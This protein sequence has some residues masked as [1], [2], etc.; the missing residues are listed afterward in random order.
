MSAL[1]LLAMGCQSGKSTRR[2]PRHHTIENSFTDSSARSEYVDRRT[3]ELVDKGVDRETASARASREWFAH[4]PVATQVPTA[5]ELKR[6]QAEADITA[7]LE[8]RKEPG[9]R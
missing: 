7:Y 9:D 5:Y 2:Q 4:A 6:R 3:Q 8:K 1:L